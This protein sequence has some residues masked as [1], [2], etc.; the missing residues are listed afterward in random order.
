MSG[1]RTVTRLLLGAAVSLGVVLVSALPAHA[2]NKGA[3]IFRG[4]Y[5]YQG[6]YLNRQKVNYNYSV[7]LIMQPDGNLVL[8]RTTGYVCWAAGTN[9]GG[10]HARY[11]SDGNFVVYRSDGQSLWASNTVGASGESVSIEQDGSFWVGYKK[12]ASC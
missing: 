6:D 10:N 2:V 11:Q 12:I 5:L 9:P 3:Q 7:Q 1:K 4:A 8:K